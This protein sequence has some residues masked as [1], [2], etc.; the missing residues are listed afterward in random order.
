MAPNE[1]AYIGVILYAGYA[2]GYS[3]LHTLTNEAM[4]THD[5]N[6]VHI[7]QCGILERDLDR[8]HE[9]VIIMHA[10]HENGIDI[11]VLHKITSPSII[12]GFYQFNK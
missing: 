6:L 8:M 3:R 4:Y 2:T 5:H 12:L 10:F 1:K 9:K 7:F 11:F